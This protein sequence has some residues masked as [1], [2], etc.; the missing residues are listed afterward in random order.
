MFSCNGLTPDLSSQTNDILG[1]KPQDIDRIYQNGID[2]SSRLIYIS[3]SFTQ[4]LMLFNLLGDF[5]SI[6]TNLSNLSGFLTK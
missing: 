1:S 3:K 2:F 6:V 5:T 4:S